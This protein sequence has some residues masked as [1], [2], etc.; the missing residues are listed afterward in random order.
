MA[1]SS[2]ELNRIFVAASTGGQN[3]VT[4]EEAEKLYFDIQTEIESLDGRMMAEPI[5]E[6][7]DDTYDE[8]LEATHKA[9]GEYGDYIWDRDVAKGQY[10]VAK[11]TR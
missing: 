3:P 4:G 6:W 8:L 9:W 7:A 2:E 1:L 10:R 11:E 5:N